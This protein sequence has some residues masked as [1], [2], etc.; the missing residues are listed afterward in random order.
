M[1]PTLETTT[2]YIG[3]VRKELPKLL[4]EKIGAGHTDWMM[5]LQAV[6][7]VDVDHIRDGVDIWK[8]EQD[9]QDTLNSSKSSLIIVDVTLQEGVYENYKHFNE[10]RIVDFA[11]APKFSCNLNIR[12]KRL[13]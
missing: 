11:Y 3:Q 8:K 6:R 1:S 10:T 2:T 12:K 7:D 4:R 13:G 5:F 9:E